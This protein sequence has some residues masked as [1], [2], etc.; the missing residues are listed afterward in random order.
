MLLALLSLSIHVLIGQT[1]TIYGE[2]YDKESKLP[3]P[4]LMV[5]NKRTNNGTFADSEGKFTI[6]A[7]QSD[8]LMLSAIG[9]RVKKISLKDSV[10]KK[11]YTILVPLEKLY[12]TLK[13]VSVFAPR[14]L[15]EIQKDIDKLGVKRTYS[16]ENIDAISSPIT[17]LYER[18]SKFGRSKQKVAEWENEDMKRDILK[19]LFRL[20]I[21]H[22]IIDLSEE[23]FDAFIKYLQLSDEFIKNASQLE[24]VLAIKGKYENFK[25]RW[26]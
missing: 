8:T 10:A 5:I 15:N 21:K 16:T 13:E 9:F 23:E 20:Y 17:Y 26:K 22:D 25:Y 6:T 4:K 14:S 3:L 12:F 1:V 18:F 19:D 7:L 2:A 11:Q 24:L